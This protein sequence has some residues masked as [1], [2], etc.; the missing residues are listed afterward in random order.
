VNL[1]LPVRRD[2]TALRKLD[3]VRAFTLVELLVVIAIIVI[4]A[5]LLSPVLTRAKEAS[6]GASCLNNLRQL[7]LA[8]MT[9]SLDNRGRL[10]YFLDWLYTKPGDLTSGRLFPYLK[11]KAVYLCP[12]DKIALSTYARMP[13]P[14]NGPV[15]GNSYHPRD[16]SYGINCCLCHE[17]DTSKYIAPTRTLFMMEPDLAQNDYSG[18]V[19]PSV[20]TMTVSTRHNRRGHL[21]YCDMHSERVSQ[22]VAQRLEKSRLFWFPTGD[23]TG[24]GGMNLSAGLTDP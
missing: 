22:K 3:E 14:P 4:L 11:T 7:G 1:P 17:G 24:P 23:L 9:Y 12:T 20:A 19:G 21:L 16:Y 8:S 2:V 18:Q 13:A 15:F 6:R 10:P 5:G